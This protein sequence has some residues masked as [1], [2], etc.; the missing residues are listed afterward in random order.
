MVFFILFI[1]KILIEILI[2]F[3]I[4]DEFDDAKMQPP[5]AVGMVNNL[6]EMVNFFGQ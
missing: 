1:V 6:V 5:Q 4:R 2:A 3:Q